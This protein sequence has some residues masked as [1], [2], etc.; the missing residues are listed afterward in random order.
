MKN[1]DQNPYA[2]WLIVYLTLDQKLKSRQ[3]ASETT[4]LTERVGVK[5]GL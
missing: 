4:H 3:Y 1:I 2:T 5:Y